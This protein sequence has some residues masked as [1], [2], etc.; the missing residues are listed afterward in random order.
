MAIQEPPRLRESAQKNSRGEFDLES[1]FNRELYPVINRIQA[2]V[3]EV[4]AGLNR[5]RPKFISAATYAITEDDEMSLIVMDWP[6]AC[7]VTMDSAI[8]DTYEDGAVIAMLQWTAS[9][10]IT[11]V[12][13]GFNV[14]PSETQKTRKIDSGMFIAR[15]RSGD[16]WLTGDLEL[17]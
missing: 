6:T 5:F 16:W 10:Q 1:I 12:E 11:F 17:T 7:T 13:T 4:I 9:G 15:L 14:H 2:S 3:V 8:A